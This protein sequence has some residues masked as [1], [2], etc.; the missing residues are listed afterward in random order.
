[1]STGI[2]VGVPG[3]TVTGLT[4]E[5]VGGRTS[6]D[7][8][9]P[10]TSLELFATRTYPPG[11]PFTVNVTLNQPITQGV[12]TTY[13]INETGNGYLPRVLCLIGSG[14]VTTPSTTTGSTTS[15]TTTTLPKIVPTPLR[16][17]LVSS[18][19]DMDGLWWG[20]AALGVV[21]VVSFIMIH[22][23]GKG[24][25]GS[26]GSDK[27]G[28]GSDGCDP[29]W[30]CDDDDDDSSGEPRTRLGRL[31]RRS[32]ELRLLPLTYDEFGR[33][34]RRRDVRQ[35]SIPELAYGDKPPAHVSEVPD[36]RPDEPGTGTTQREDAPGTERADDPGAGTGGVAGGAGLTR[37]D[38]APVDDCAALRAACERARADVAAKEA[39]ARE[40][41]AAAKS[42]RD[43]CQTAG[44]AVASA[45]A[46][47]D[48]ALAEQHR[49]GDG[50]WVEDAATGERVSVDDTHA[51]NQA[52]Q[53]AWN[54]YR[55]GEI[56]AQQLEDEWNRVASPDAIR[57]L[58]EQA[59]R[60]RTERIGAARRTLEEKKQEQARVC[61]AAD[62]AEADAATLEQAAAN[63]R[64]DATA[65]CTA[66]D[67]CERRA[68]ATK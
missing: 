3:A 35:P 30:C 68:S 1:V 8:L 6:T 37:T 53:A 66:A 12:F 5:G 13:L 63:A 7:N 64:A 33:P 19:S 54:R 56:D 14:G 21:L 25:M 34:L 26:S 11:Q 23:T 65:I 38:D 57:R 31:F 67:D 2:A 18:S 4:V 55:S 62:K 17:R 9:P 20:L 36:D 27:E 10:G 22:T 44:A 58:R 50:S 51:V 45:Q 43:A 47:L 59:N 52:A 41:S 28:E 61:A 49:A 15:T 39:R 48:R 60:A 29:C 16:A 40:A 42:A 32:D 46:D 24:S